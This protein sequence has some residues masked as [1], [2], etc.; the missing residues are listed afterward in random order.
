VFPNE[1]KYDNMKYPYLKD[2]MQRKIV[3]MQYIL[4]EG[5]LLEGSRSISLFNCYG[6]CT[7]KKLFWEAVANSGLLAIKNLIL[8]R[9][10]NFTMSS[11]KVGVQKPN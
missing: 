10:L 2:M 4:L 7:D 9:D 3:H 8:A 1:S 11:S 6:P 5:T